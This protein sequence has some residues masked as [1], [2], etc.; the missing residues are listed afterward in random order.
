MSQYKPRGHYEGD[1]LLEAYFRAMMWL[2]R[3][4]FRLVATTDS[5]AQVLQRPQVDAMLLLQ[6]L[7][8]EADLV[9]FQHVDDVVRAFVGESDNMTLEQVPALLTALGVKDAAGVAKISDEK[10]QQ[11]I[12]EHGFGKQ[13]I[14]SHLMA[15]GLDAALP[16]NAS[17]LLFGQRY[18][19]D[20]RV[21]SNVVWDRVREKRMMPD[22]LDVAFAALGNDQAASLLREQ[23][24]EY[25]Y[26]GDLAAMRTLIDAHDEE[27][28]R[29]N[30][31]NDWLSALRTLSPS[32]ASI[33]DPAAMGMPS[34]TANSAWGRRLLN[35]QLA[36]WA[37]LRHDTILYAK[38]SYGSVASCRFPDAAVDPYPEFYAAVGRFAD[39]GYELANLAD[40]TSAEELGD[41]MRDFFGQMSDVAAMLK[42]I[43]QSERA[44]SALT[45]EQLAFINDAVVLEP[46]GCTTKKIARGWYAR[47]FFDWNKPLEDAPT[48]ADVY[49]QPT[50]EAGN[51]VGRILNV[52]TAGPRLMVVTDDGCGAPKAYVGLA[53]SYYEVITEN[54]LRMSDS[55]WEQRLS[56]EGR[57]AEAA[58]MQ[59]L[60]PL[61]K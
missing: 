25:D 14:M 48:I 55:D 44:G 49:T 26:A 40:G 36:S 11:T 57:P 28:W 41:R 53:S 4:D 18:I 61:P 15:G 10:L 23:L 58:W 46:F 35:T 33:K 42:T 13:Q 56:D 52:A 24:Q 3:I 59:D 30:L 37:Q 43:A 6:S 16:L 21:L 29:K 8:G 60:I 54:W 5:G 9:R 39:H 38:Q 27:F 32:V 1:R 2:G 17:F 22:P 34:L 7:F 12:L 19:V 47:L 20:S 51:D 45:A 31:Y 50:D